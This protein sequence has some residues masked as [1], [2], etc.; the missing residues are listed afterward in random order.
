MVGTNRTAVVNVKAMVYGAWICS[1]ANPRSSADVVMKK[2]EKAETTP[3]KRIEKAIDW[4]KG[5]PKIKF[6][7][8]MNPA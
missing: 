3:R 8:K 4:T 7:M 5:V 1:R 2:T 6:M